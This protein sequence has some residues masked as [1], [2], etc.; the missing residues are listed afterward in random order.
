MLTAQRIKGYNAQFAALAQCYVTMN[1]GKRYNFAHAITLKATGKKTKVKVNILGQ[2]TKGNKA[3]GIEYTGTMTMH[4][5]NSIFRKILHD[6]QVDG[7]DI[8]FNMVIT[9]Y[10]PTAGNGQQTITLVNCNLDETV[11][12][13]FDASSTDVLTEDAPFT[14]DGFEINEEFDT[15]SVILEDGTATVTP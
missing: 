6:Y 2:T 13:A 7:T 9:N 14:F 5:N 10:D 8:Y 12:T 1:D 4:Y 3:A 11:V 15:L